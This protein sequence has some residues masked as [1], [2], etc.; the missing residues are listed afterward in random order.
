M[1]HIKK[2]DREKVVIQ[3]DKMPVASVILLHGLGANAAELSEVANYLQLPE[4]NIRF[5]FPNAPLMP[6]T[7]NGGMLMPAWYDILGLSATSRQDKEG[8]LEAKTYLDGL[9]DQEHQHGIPYQRIFLG[10]FSQGGALALFA[11][12]HCAQRIGG[13]IG[14]STYLPI[15]DSLAPLHRSLPVFLA[16]GTHDEVLPLAWAKMAREQLQDVGCEVAWHEF[17]FDHTINQEELLC[18]SQWLSTMLVQ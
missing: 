16:H 3:P 14:L 10:G 4:K 13:V 18:L 2:F 15:A 12:L 7:L 9:I 5:V 1:R 8:I 11:G 6:V 17:A